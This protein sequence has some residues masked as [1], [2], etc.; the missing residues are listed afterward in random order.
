MSDG[1]LVDD[2]RPGDDHGQQF[3]RLFLSHERRLRG[4]IL[5]M[6]PNWTDAEDVLQETSAVMWRKF[7]QFTPGTDFAAWALAIARFQALDF[8]KRRKV[9]RAKFS[10]QLLDQI[11]DEVAARHREL[12]AR[13]DALEHC[14]GK[15]NDRDRTLIRLRYTESAT[16][17]QVAQQTGRTI[18]AVYKALNRLHE[19][20]LQCVRSAMIR[21]N[22]V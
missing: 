20:L 14:L 19:A 11:A 1:S 7:D 8:I 6:V 5:T 10:D 3:M 2:A 15:L 17:Q 4:L 12:D 9:R 21:E 16:P 13:H 22:T 18:H